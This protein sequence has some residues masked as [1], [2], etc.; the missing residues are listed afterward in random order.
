[1]GRAFQANQCGLI[2]QPDFIVHVAES[3]VGVGVT[4]VGN[5][6]AG[7]IAIIADALLLRDQELQLGLDIGLADLIQHSGDLAGFLPTQP[8]QCAAHPAVVAPARL[9]P[10]LGY[11]QVLVQRMGGQADVLQ[12]LQPG[13]DGHQEL[14]DFA[15]RC[16][17]VMFL[18]EGHR[19]KSPDQAD[20]FAK[21]APG[22][23]KGVLGVL[24]FAFVV[25]H[26][27]S[28]LVREW[29]GAYRVRIQLVRY[30]V[31]PQRDIFQFWAVFRDSASDCTKLTLGPQFCNRKCS[32]IALGR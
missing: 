25:A 13:Q 22:H 5:R 19:Q 1:M 20:V 30:G 26:N 15:L 27:R 28:S 3:R 9:S 23:Q 16:V 8:A 11:R 6:Q 31:A 2:P 24:N 14:Q 18:V 4:G 10:G 7:Q 32:F 21:P 12:M 17:M 29:S